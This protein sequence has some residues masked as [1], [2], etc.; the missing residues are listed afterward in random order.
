MFC[1]GKTCERMLSWNIC[2]TWNMH[3]VRYEKVKSAAV[4]MR[5]LRCRSG[6]CQ[7]TVGPAFSSCPST[8]LWLSTCTCFFPGLNSILANLIVPV[9]TFVSAILII[10][11]SAR[12]STGLLITKP[13]LSFMYQT[14]W[15]WMVLA[16]PVN[17]IV[18]YCV[19]THSIAFTTLSW[20][21][22]C[23]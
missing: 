6:S 1:C 23:P 11:A 8:K 15:L 13:I 17:T 10:L 9:N 21:D 19:F 3:L 14:L 2:A 16:G 20:S 22:Q 7:F 5:F 18:L 12:P 4:R